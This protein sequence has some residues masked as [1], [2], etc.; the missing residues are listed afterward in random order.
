MMSRLPISDV[1]WKQLVQCNQR[2]VTEGWASPGVFATG[3]GPDYGLRKQLA[4]LYVGKSA[5]PLGDRVG[6]NANQAMSVAASTKWMI[7]K[8]NKSAFWQMVDLIDPSRRH[9]AWT[10]ICKMDELGGSRPPPM[11]RWQRIVEPHRMALK[12]EIAFLS[13][14][15]ILFATSG[16]CGETISHLLEE[17]GY[18]TQ[19]VNF[20]D[21]YTKL[22]ATSGGAFAIETRHPQGWPSIERNRV[23]ELA[24]KLLHQPT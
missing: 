3:I 13:P 2:A 15:V 11:H 14:R 7:E 21:G 6:S 18:R 23:V 1:T 22:A 4:L 19:A 5:G 20:R 10:N 12:E 24:R 9:I 8:R 17:L 16:Y